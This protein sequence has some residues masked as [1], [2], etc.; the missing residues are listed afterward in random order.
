MIE[1]KMDPESWNETLA[2]FPNPPILQTWQWGEVKQHFGWQAEHMLWKN[3]QKQITGMALVLSRTMSW[4]G[5][6]PGWKVIYVPRG[7]VLRDWSDSD[8][9]KQIIRDIQSFAKQQN[10]IFVKIDPE[11]EVARG[12]PGELNFQENTQ[13]LPI[14]EEL[15][16]QGWIFSQEQIQFRNTVV[17]DLSP[18]EDDLLAQ[19]KQKTRYN[20][21]LAGRQR[22][23]VRQG[24]REDFDLLYQMYAETSLRDGFVIRDRTYYFRVWDTFFQA[25]LAIP[26]IAE[27]D[28]IPISGL[29]LF[30]FGHKAWF[31]Y[32]M[33]TD[34]HREKMPSYKLQWEAIQAAKSAGCTSYDLWGAP[35][36][37]VQ[38]DKLWGVY[39]FK[40][41][42][43]GQVVQYL[44]AWDYPV[45]PTI[46][47]VYTRIIPRVLGWMRRRGR[48]QTQYS[49]N[50]GSI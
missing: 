34:S 38:Q 40:E 44:G 1:S 48:S 19:M 25:G 30:I 33:S 8:T 23:N 10:A 20:I 41:G 22:V 9:R 50:A 32:G 26:L 35:D 39:R 6:T 46:Y 29:W 28:G 27:V 14:L 18:S 15:N 36:Q 49:L 11:L 16:E 31:L 43:G 12:L 7:P 5:F 37:F 42:F 45:N 2:T 24:T 21:R 4:R 17:L 3:D 13:A 47:R